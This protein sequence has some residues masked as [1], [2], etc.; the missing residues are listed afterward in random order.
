[1]KAEEAFF[2]EMLQSLNEDERRRVEAWS[3]HYREWARTVPD[4]WARFDLR[5][6][7][8]RWNAPAD[9]YDRLRRTFG[10]WLEEQH[11]PRGS[12]PRLHEEFLALNKELADL[13]RGRLA[14]AEIDLGVEEAL[15]RD[16]LADP[17]EQT[18]F[19]V[20][21]DWLEERDDPR[22]QQ[23]RLLARVRVLGRQ[24]PLAWLEAS[25]VPWPSLPHT[26]QNVGE[27]A[28]RVMQLANQEAQRCNH[29]YLSTQ[30]VLL[31]LLRRDFPVTPAALTGLGI[32]LPA[33]REEVERLT[34]AGPDVI[35]A[36]KLPQS[37]R[38]KAAIDF[39]VEEAEAL[40]HEVVSPE[41]LLLGLC[42]A[43]PCNATRVLHALGVS[44]GAVC[45]RVLAD[46][47]RDSLRWLRQH[48][49]VW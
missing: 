20:L 23:V 31:G 27:P 5:F 13:G 7:Y 1:V 45:R 35:I 17:A 49:E 6:I 8:L 29:E 10:T 47:G 48:P 30:H 46:L 44:P 40:G 43:N 21:A 42:R 26:Y 37:T 38:G 25:A 32:T 18:A 11:D 34:P 16:I 2:Q 33:T 3:G 36:S 15:L 4:P 9:T 19:L 39:A 41:H 22:A 24:L 14:E 12:W 28:R